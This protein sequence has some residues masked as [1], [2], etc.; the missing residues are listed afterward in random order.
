MPVQTGLPV[1]RAAVF[2]KA[3][4]V[5][6]AGSFPQAAVRSL[7]AGLG[8]VHETVASSRRAPRL[9]V[10]QP[11]VQA[12]VGVAVLAG[13]QADD[14]DVGRKAC[15]GRKEQ[16][17]SQ[18][19]SLPVGSNHK[20]AHLCGSPVGPA[21]AD[22]GHQAPVLA[23]SPCHDLRVGQLGA[24]LAECLGQR[25]HREVAVGLGLGHVRRP[26]E[27]QDLA[28][29]ITAQAQRDDLVHGHTPSLPARSIRGTAD[30]YPLNRHRHRQVGGSTDIFS[31]SYNHADPQT[32]KL[33]KSSYLE[34]A[35]NAPETFDHKRKENMGEITGK[36]VREI[37]H[38]YVTVLLAGSKEAKKA[39]NESRS[40]ALKINDGLS[41]SEISTDPDKIL[42]LVDS[43]VLAANSFVKVAERELS[44]VGYLG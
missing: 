32:S 43:F 16:R 37:N 44:L 4:T 40:A 9:A 34:R 28:G 3:R 25:A 24:K 12:Q 39:A 29:I 15:F 17:G 42:A 19:A 1:G 2:T 21:D 13:E 26:L 30:K 8:E 14:R 22:A 10:A 36:A 20:T 27:R 31:G 41:Q 18:P 23:D 5:R 33:R 11:L 35:W 7:S 6:T 38:A